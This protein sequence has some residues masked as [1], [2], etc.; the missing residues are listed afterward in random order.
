VT[1][2]DGSDD[3]DDGDDD[4]EKLILVQDLLLH[5]SMD[6][7]EI[8]SFCDTVVVGTIGKGAPDFRIGFT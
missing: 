3:D 4:E 5:K 7:F 2:E 8:P 6:V 1:K